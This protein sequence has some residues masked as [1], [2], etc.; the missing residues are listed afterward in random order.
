MVGKRKSLVV[1][2]APGLLVN[3]ITPGFEKTIFTESIRKNGAISLALIKSGP[4]DGSPILK[5]SR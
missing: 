4:V 5:K 3:A 2:W 1:E